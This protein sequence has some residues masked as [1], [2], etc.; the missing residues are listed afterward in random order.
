MIPGITEAGL[1]VLQKWAGG[2]FPYPTNIEHTK[3]KR[4][5]ILHCVSN[6]FPCFQ[7]IKGHEETGNHQFWAIHYKSLNLNGFLSKTHH[8]GEFPRR[9]LGGGKLPRSVKTDKSANHHFVSF[10]LANL[11]SPSRWPLVCVDPVG[12]RK[13]TERSES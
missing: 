11:G 13:P 4:I 6:F 8:F 10:H 2:S 7:N 1:E 5:P 12:R 9:E 3:Q